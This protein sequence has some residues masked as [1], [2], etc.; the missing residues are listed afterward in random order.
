MAAASPYIRL[1][2]AERHVFV[3]ERR[4]V[5]TS[6]MIR[7][8]LGGGGGFAES[9]KGE[10][11]FGEISTAVLEKVVAYMHYKAK[12][13]N[14]KVP[15]PDFAIAPEMALEVLSAANYLDL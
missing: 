13:H 7:T 1:I 6:G 14:S 2:S 3:V 11:E 10:I 12:H 5:L 4:I 15:I 9:A 8:M